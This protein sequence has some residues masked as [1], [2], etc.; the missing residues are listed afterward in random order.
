MLDLYSL[1]A[2]R[3][4]LVESVACNALREV[5]HGWM[6]PHLDW[7]PKETRTAWIRL[8]ERRSAGDFSKFDATE[9]RALL[10]A[11]HA[12]IYYLGPE[13]LQTLTGQSLEDFVSAGRIMFSGMASN[14]YVSK[15]W[16][17]ST[18]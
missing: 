17:D 2:E 10:E 6:P 11:V 15:L 1:V 16:T 5:L 13:E 18:P 4:S 7:V 9:L 3:R 14:V 12:T 8:E